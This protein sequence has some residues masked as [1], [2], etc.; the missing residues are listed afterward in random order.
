MTKKY[1]TGKG[2]DTM[3]KSVCVI[4]KYVEENM[5]EEKKSQLMR[6]VYRTISVGHYNEDFAKE[7][8]AKMY[9]FDKSEDRHDAPYWPDTAIK[10][11]YEKY[12]SEIPDYDMYDFAVTLNMI[13]SDNWCMIMSWF[14]NITD[15]ERNEKFAEMS[16]NWL[17]DDDWPTSTKIWDYLNQMA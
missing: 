10:E 7:D 1:S 8:I 17:K 2:E 3:W 5:P 16:V 11:L 12:K 6:D 13:A 15:S 14:P 9:Y 4:S